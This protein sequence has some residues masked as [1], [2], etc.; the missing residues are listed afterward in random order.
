[1]EL[2]L[3]RR[4]KKIEL[5]DLKRHN[6]FFAQ[7]MAQKFTDI[8]SSGNFILGQEVAAFEEE[9]AAYCGVSFAVGVSSG[10]DAL[11][12]VLLSCGVGED[13][14]VITVANSFFSTTMAIT[15]AGARPVFVDIDPITYTIDPDLIEKSITSKTKAILPVHLYGQPAEM[16]PI[17][18]IARKRGLLVVEDA[19]QAHG[20]MYNGRP[21]GSLGDAGCFSFYP[22]KNLG[23]LGDGG[24][25]TTNDPTIAERVRLMRNYGQQSKNCHICH[26][27]NSRLDSLQAALLMLKLP[28]L[29]NFNSKRRANAKMYS[30]LLD[31]KGVIAPR[32]APSTVHSYHI[33]ALR[34]SQRDELRD[35]LAQKG[36]ATGIHYPVPA[37][38]QVPFMAL[39][40]KT[41]DLPQT[42]KHCSEVLSL[43]MFPELTCEEIEYIALSINQFFEKGA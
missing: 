15:M 3:K 5:V 6:S 33:Y 35:F 13:D 39:G 7:Q 21:C 9:F 26:G 41:G 19:C 27:F 31:C 8:V 4:V 29:K 30:S 42:E 22:T 43:P 37:H 20:A 1:M 36:V 32:S 38:L 10:T 24:A 12:L 11:F 34:T 40:Y 23:A 25:V 28:H 14:E 17:M 2:S 16:G 18:E